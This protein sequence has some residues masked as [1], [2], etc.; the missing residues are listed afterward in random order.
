MCRS[1]V[2]MLLL[3][4]QCALTNAND[5]T[6][7]KDRQAVAVIVLSAE[8]GWIERHA[9]NELSQFV[10]RIT[11]AS[12]PIVETGPVSVHKD[13]TRILIGSP[14]S[15]A[16]IRHLVG[17]GVVELERGAMGVDGFAIKHAVHE[18]YQY[19]ILSGCRGRSYMYAVYDFL[20]QEC[21]VGYFW[22]GDQVPQQSTLRVSVSQR[23]ERPY[24][25]RRMAPNACSYVYSSQYWG[26]DEW[27]RAHDYMLKRKLNVSYFTF[28]REVV[29]DRVWQRFGMQAQP[30]SEWALWEYELQQAVGE[31]ARK[32]DMELVGQLWGGHVS[33]EFAEAHPHLKYVVAQW[34]GVSTSYNIHPQ[35][36]MFGKVVEASIKE[37]KATYGP[38]QLWDQ[39][40]Y[41]E[42][43]PGAT[44]AEKRQ[45]KLDWARHMSAALARADAHGTLYM[46]GW[47]LQGPD[48]TPEVCRE[49]FG[50]MTH[51]RFLVADVWAETKPVFV[52]TGYFGGEAEWMFGVLNT[53]GN[54]ERL[55]GDLRDL[56]RR[57]QHVVREPASSRCTGFYINPE[58]THHNFLYFDFASE[59]AWDPREVELHAF[60]RRYCVRRYGITAA[61]TMVEVWKRVANTAYADNLE[62]NPRPFYQN[63]L[64]YDGGGADLFAD[65]QKVKTRYSQTAELWQALRLAVTQRRELEANRF[66]QRD[67]IDIARTLL[68]MDFDYQ[69]LRAY[70]A[71]TLRSDAVAVAAAGRDALER[72]QWVESLTATREEFWL[73]NEINLGRQRPLRRQPIHSRAPAGTSRL[74]AN[75]R[76]VRLRYTALAGMDK[77]P[78]LLDYAST[79]R[80]ELLRGYYRPRVK[81]W[82]RH[83]QERLH[84]GMN[85]VDYGALLQGAYRD[86]AEDFVGGQT[87]QAGVVPSRE[88]ALDIVEALLEEYGIRDAPP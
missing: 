18:G 43:S 32:L 87:A 72:L 82:L 45:I 37:W 11:G 4:C 12:L 21:G 41:P 61:P 77:Y 33:P 71:F 75:D 51:S 6:L 69:A 27:K 46:S 76:E 57:V 20:E 10:L 28:G 13:S 81:A 56:L 55:H 3:G 29:M 65:P 2:V 24:F 79:D 25:K 70:Q 19:L 49:F 80:V 16:Q 52:K 1:I 31:Y 60:L 66:Y 67:V 17:E 73:A 64:P 74:P 9:A 53:F 59:L 47:F 36:P 38:T 84:E 88:T 7:V 83:M 30:L 22:D 35:D 8:A 44:A 86:I 85:S 26:V 68:G 63:A 62:A 48:W 78:G 5:V 15:H 58:S 40:P 54:V 50:A 39:A 42:T 23:T 34:A 14:Q